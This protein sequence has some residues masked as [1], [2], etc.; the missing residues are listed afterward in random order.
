MEDVGLKSPQV[1]CQ[2]GLKSWNSALPSVLGSPRASAKIR[3]L[4]A[5]TSGVNG[6]ITEAGPCSWMASSMASAMSERASSQETGSNLPSPRSPT[7]LRGW[8]TRSGE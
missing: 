3:A 7:R 4:A 5:P 8:V 2:P 6:V 1:R